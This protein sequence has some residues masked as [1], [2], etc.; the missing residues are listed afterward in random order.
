MKPRHGIWK[1]V[2]ELRG[3]ICYIK[4]L[5]KYGSQGLTEDQI[6]IYNELIHEYEDRINELIGV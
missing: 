3:M 2:Y 6:D 5:L 1:E 4:A